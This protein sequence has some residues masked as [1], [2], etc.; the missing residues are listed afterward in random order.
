[1][2]VRDDIRL[3]HLLDNLSKNALHVDVGILRITHA[4]K[5]A[6]EIDGIHLPD[7]ISETGRVEIGFDGA[8]A[9]DQVG[10]LDYLANTGIGSVA[11][12]H[13]TEVLVCLVHSALAHWGYKG[14]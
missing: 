10:G 13:A 2:E 1:M 3:A 5:V 7:A 6:V 8:N 9:E 12:I 11:G 14:G 4:H